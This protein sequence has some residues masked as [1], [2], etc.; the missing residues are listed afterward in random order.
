[1]FKNHE[2]YKHNFGQINCQDQMVVPGSNIL[3]RRTNSSLHEMAEMALKT[4][5][6]GEIPFVRRLYKRDKDGQFRDTGEYETIYR[7]RKSLLSY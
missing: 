2:G 1:M 7:H 3:N 4:A 6:S 5:R